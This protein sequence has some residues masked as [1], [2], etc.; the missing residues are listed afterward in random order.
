ML[1]EPGVVEHQHPI[2]LGRQGGHHPDPLAVQV[3]VVPGHGCEQPLETLLGRAGDESGEGVAVLVRVLGQQAG[4]V[5]L[6]GGRPFPPSELNP[7]RGEELGQLRH[8]FSRGGRETRLRCHKPL[9]R[10]TPGKVTK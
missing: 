3:V 9:N 6:Q 10:N 7:E 2:P 1:G 5:P 4:A 8:G